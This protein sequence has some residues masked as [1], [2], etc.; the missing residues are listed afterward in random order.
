MIK[1]L[2]QR[3]D[4]LGIEY[5]KNI[6]AEKLEQ[7][8]IDFEQEQND[9]LAEETK[10]K[11][12][13]P[14]KQEE[15]KEVKPETML[16][17]AMKKRMDAEKLQYVVITSNDERDREEEVCFLGFGNKYFELSRLVPFGQELWLEKGLV[18]IAKSTRILQHVNE[19]D[20][21]GRNTGNKTAKLVN[22]YNVSFPKGE[23]YTEK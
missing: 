16:Q 9:K 13:E 14:K 19:L 12:K 20:R 7:R 18:A 17:K 4:E 6:S 1:E 3:A 15:P 21:N 8:I 10:V 2:K 11:V 23:E 5:A 22:R